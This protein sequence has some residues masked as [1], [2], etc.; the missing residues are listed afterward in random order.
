[1]LWNYI[2]LK[3]KNINKIFL[4]G[5][6]IIYS[7]YIHHKNMQTILIKN[8]N[9]IKNSILGLKPKL[10][11]E[12]LN[13]LYYLHIEPNTFCQGITSFRRYGK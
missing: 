13:L 7:K 2:L 9:T 12:S 10:P 8:D 1:M 4:S 6:H 3:I 5:L 11:Y